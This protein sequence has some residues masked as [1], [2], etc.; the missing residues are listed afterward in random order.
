MKKS[1]CLLQLLVITV[2][3]Y[4]HLFLSDIVFFGVRENLALPKI[5]IYN[6]SNE[7]GLAH[8]FEFEFIFVQT[9]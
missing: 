8:T 6:D 9:F 4:K 2:T 5:S 7:A 3:Q 1:N